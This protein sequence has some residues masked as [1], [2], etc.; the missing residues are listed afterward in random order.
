MPP[1]YWGLACR[2]KGPDQATKY[3]SGNGVAVEAMCADRHQH[4][5]VDD[6]E[7]GG[8]VERR[9]TPIVTA[10]RVLAWVLAWVLENLSPE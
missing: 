3:C 1:G 5:P 4:R 7:G 10:T 9:L 8:A 6:N 2:Q